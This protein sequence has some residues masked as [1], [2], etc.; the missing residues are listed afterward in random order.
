MKRSSTLTAIVAKHLKSNKTTKFALI[1]HLGSINQMKHFSVKNNM[2]FDQ[3]YTKPNNDTIFFMP[4]QN[5]IGVN[6]LANNLGNY[7]KSLNC[8]KPL[9]VTDK[10]LRE[11]GIVGM[12][13]QVL[14]SQNIPYEIFD[15]VQPNPTVKNVEEGLSL[16]NSSNCDCLISLGG[17]SAHD[18]CKAIGLVKENGGKIQ[19]YEGLDKS[20]KRVCP[21]I[22]INTTAGTAAEM[23][24]FS[25]ITD[26]ERKV[27]MAIVDKN[28][29]PNMSINDPV[30]MMKQPPFLTACTGLDALT[31]AIE[32]YVSTISNP[33]SDACA[34]QAIELI[35]KHLTKA[36]ANGQD[37]N[38]REAMCYAQFLAGMAFNNASLGYVHAIAHQ[39]GGFYNMAH[40]LCNALLLPSV[41]KFNILPQA[42]KLKRVAATLGEDVS[43]LTD[44]EG[45]ERAVQAVLKLRTLC[46]IPNGLKEFKEVKKEDF[47]LLADHALKDVCGFTNPRVATKKDIIGILEESYNGL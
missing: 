15:K 12:V 45:A 40:G 17:G 9:I 36:V 7:I 37:I 20:A 4:A 2:S 3:V 14:D 31:H 10:P 32:A 33:L 34:L 27:K 35:S 21:Y 24:R 22:A 16:M 46:G 23:T 30:L 44:Y 26:E 13:T 39:L 19:D 25:I 1:Q 43:G 18:C 5:A 42:Q 29:T 11:V 38:A 41:M 6:S 8:K 28:V 47:G